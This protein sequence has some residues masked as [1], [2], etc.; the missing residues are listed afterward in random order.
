LDNAG[1]NDSVNADR[2]RIVGDTST[3]PADAEMKANGSPLTDKNLS[4]TAVAQI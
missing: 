1:W 2:E 4:A 3:N